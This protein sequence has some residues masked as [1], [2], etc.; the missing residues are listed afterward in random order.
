MQT[1]LTDREL[2][3]QTLRGNRDAFAMLVDRFHRVVFNVALRILKSSDDAQDVSQTTFLKAYEHLESYNSR[4]A[5]F[6][7]IYRIAVNESLNFLQRRRRLQGLDDDEPSVT[8]KSPED[9]YREAEMAQ[10]VQNA[11]MLLSIDHRLVI[12]LKHLEGLSYR[13]IGYILDLPTKTV[14][15]RLYE[16][17][18]NL[19]DI[20]TR[21]GLTEL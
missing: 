4:H 13:D 16:A 6:S 12:V 5:F 19:K 17:R 2:V 11:L 7:W 14:K 10:T 1:D 20:L 15:S 9:N 3:R 18:I 21:Q 8:T